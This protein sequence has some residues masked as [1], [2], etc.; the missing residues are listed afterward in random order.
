MNPIDPTS[1]DPSPTPAAVRADAIAQRQRTFQSVLG[2]VAPHEPAKTP[3]DEA[4]ETAEQLVTQTFIIPLLKQL[5]EADR[6]A[7][8]FA[9]SQGERQFR[10]LGDA[11]VAQNIT[12]S[13]RFPLVERL[14]QDLLK[15]RGLDPASL[16]EL[17]AART[18]APPRDGAPSLATH[19]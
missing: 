6:S 11:E 7:P 16:N 4:R 1:R 3:Q 9:P 19:R 10:A 2:R 14:A 13:A 8:P 12:R 15:R 5:R 17:A 18:P